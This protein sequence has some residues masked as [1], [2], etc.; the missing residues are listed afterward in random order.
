M[1]VTIT[2]PSCETIFTLF[3]AE[4]A[5]NKCSKVSLDALCPICA[6]TFRVTV[7]IDKGVAISHVDDD[8]GEE[9]DDA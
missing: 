2:C 8:E 4:F 5:P 9:G 1:K 7:K 6:S 3:D